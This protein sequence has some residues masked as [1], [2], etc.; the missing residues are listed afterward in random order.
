MTCGPVRCR[1]G[2]MEKETA[3][4]IEV[5]LEDPDLPDDAIF[6]LIVIQKDERG[7]ADR[8]RFTGNTELEAAAGICLQTAQVIVDHRAEIKDRLGN[9]NGKCRMG[10]RLH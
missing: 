3:E 10:V 5:L 7:M 4:A 1:V 9:Q 8:L 6:L 2:K